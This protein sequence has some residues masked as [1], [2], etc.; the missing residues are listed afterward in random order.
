MSPSG[1]GCNFELVK[2]AEVGFTMEAYAISIP[3]SESSNGDNQKSA[4]VFVNTTIGHQV[5]DWGSGLTVCLFM[6]AIALE[7][8]YRYHSKRRILTRYRQGGCGTLEED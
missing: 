3:D 1:K 4:K 6:S 2:S 8:I 7:Q 5:W